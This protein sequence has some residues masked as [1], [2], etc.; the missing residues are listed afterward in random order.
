MFKSFSAMIL[1]AG[2]GK[3][4]LDL[5]SKIP[6]PLLNY[7]KKRIMFYI[8]FNI[9]FQGFRKIFASL[10]YLYKYAKSV[11][12]KKYNKVNF[13]F[14]KKKLGTAGFLKNLT[15]LLNKFL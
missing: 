5:T 8:I 2:F 7:K 10:G 9:Y 13:L 15:I 12:Q 6:K 14:E 3:R 1:A 4:M 11:I